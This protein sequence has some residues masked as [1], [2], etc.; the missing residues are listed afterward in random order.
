MKGF[1]FI[2]SIL[3]VGVALSTYY[4][5]PVFEVHDSGVVV[6]TGASSGIGK[7][8]TIKLAS[9]GY[10]VVAGVR[11]EADG[12]AILNSVDKNVGKFIVPT[13]IDVTKIESID[14]AV[15][16]AQK[17]CV[18]VWE[19]EGGKVPLVLFFFLFFFLNLFK[20]FRILFNFYP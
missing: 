8:A 6:I 20:M 18:G 10:T 12:A 16:T 19:K 3:A 2:G 1:L 15:D 5:R 9:L 7:A 14:A 17:V 11:K 4:V 13:I